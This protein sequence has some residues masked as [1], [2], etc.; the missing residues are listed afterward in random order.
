MDAA[1]TQSDSNLPLC[2]SIVWSIV[3]PSI[4]SSVSWS[5]P[6]TLNPLLVDYFV[7]CLVD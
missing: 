2:W 6:S 1:T 4:G 5:K 7:H 3:F